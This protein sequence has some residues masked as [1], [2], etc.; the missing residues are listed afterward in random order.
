MRAIHLAL[1]SDSLTM[2]DNPQRGFN[3]LVE[4]YRQLPDYV[5]SRRI[6]VLDVNDPDLSVM[7]SNRRIITDERG[8][9]ICRLPNEEPN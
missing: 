2:W 3:Q 5:H 1:D 6:L 9:R 7:Q 8:E 4:A